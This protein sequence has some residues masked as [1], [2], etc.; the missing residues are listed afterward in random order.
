MKD[1][2][3]H[4][5][6]EKLDQNRNLIPL[7]FVSYNVQ[8]LATRGLEVLDLIHLVDASFI[9]CTE[10]GEQHNTVQIPDFNMFHEKGTNKN[11]GVS[12]GIGKHLKA[13]KVETKLRNTLVVDIAGLSEPLRV[14]GVYWPNSQMR[15]INEL[16]PYIIQNTIISGDFNASVAQ[17]NSPKTDKRGQ[18][19][20]DWS[21]KNLL[22]YI[23]GTTNSSKRSQRNIDL[24]FTNFPGVK[25]ETLNFGTSDHW[26]LVYKSE[27]VNFPVTTKFSITKWKYFETMLCL[28]QE[29]W[30]KQLEYMDTTAWYKEYIRFLAAWKNRMTNWYEKEKWKPA[31]PPY[32][33]EK[34]KQVKE[35]RNR[36]YR[37]R[38][39]ADRILLRKAS[40]EVKSEINK[41]RAN[42]WK[43][44]LL[45]IQCNHDKSEKTFWKHLSK[46]YRL[47]SLP[48]TKLAVGFQVITSTREITNELYKYYSSLF[49]EQKTD[50]LDETDNQI[51]K[52]YREVLDQLNACTTTIKPTCVYELKNVI[53]TLKPKKSSGFDEISNF[54][55]KRLPPTYLEC[56]SK[57]FNDW[58]KRNIFLNDWKAA[59]IVTLNKIKVG[60]HKVI[61]PARFRCYRPTPKFLRKLYCLGLDLGQKV[62][63]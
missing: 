51:E 40:R 15:D 16:S 20:L 17:W 55:I 57:C 18:E 60:S 47:Q 31:L 54:M 8:G 46:I 35:I 48:F 49:T 26:P 62:I 7:S 3:K 10:V 33:R 59:K 50:K 9:V 4:G 30:S 28:L 34:L 52:E 61:K 36:F 41:Y 6:K 25:G 37:N 58:M 29:F 63:T 43:E 24:T 38:I 13:C 19:I 2:E 45:N 53:R 42:R 12:I 56:L 27:H 23:A 32:I 21:D 1:W 14:I 11:G 22:T 39:E 44:F 5:N